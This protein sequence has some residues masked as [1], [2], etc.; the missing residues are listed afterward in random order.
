MSTTTDSLRDI[1]LDV[2][3]EETI[4]EHQQEDRSRDPIDDEEA[5]L[6]A[7]VSSVAME[8]GLD[9]AVAGAEVDVALSE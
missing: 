7:V 9:D 5:E 6:E 4:T 8:D 1:Y 3:G 2:A